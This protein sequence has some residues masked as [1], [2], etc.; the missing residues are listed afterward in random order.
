MRA[1]QDAWKQGVFDPDNKTLGNPCTLLPVYTR[2]SDAEE[3]ERIRFAKQ[4][5][6]DS[7]TKNILLEQK[8]L[9]TGVQGEAP[10]SVIRYQP[11]ENV[12]AESVAALEQQVMGSDAWSASQ[13]IDELPRADRTWWAAYRVSNPQK[14]TVDPREDVLV[15]YAGG[16]IV[17]GQVQILKSLRAPNVVVWALRVNSSRVWHLMR[18]IWAPTK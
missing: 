9:E 7:Q 17:D 14:R 3:H 2:L 4:G 12:W 16:W 11:L 10:H 5:D 18:A 1:A 15:G 13:I 6:A 8:D